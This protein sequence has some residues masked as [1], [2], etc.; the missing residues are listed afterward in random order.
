M[1]RTV[2]DANLETRTARARL[3]ASGKPYYRA[4]D[5]G[6]HLGYRR[7]KTGGKWVMR[8]YVGDGAYEVQT[9]ATVA[10]HIIL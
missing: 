3:K 8:W 7:G 4:I 2:R 9:L 5:P 6:L 1:A 10:F